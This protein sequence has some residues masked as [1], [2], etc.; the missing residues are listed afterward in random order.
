[1]TIAQRILT[2]WIAAALA[3]G[4][5]A[6]TYYVAPGGDNGNDGSAGAPWATIQYAVDNVVSGDVVHVEPGT[7]VESV[8]ITTDYITVQGDSAANTIV[9]SVNTS[10]HACE[11]TDAH[12][13][14]LRRFTF[15]G[16]SSGLYARNTTGQ[17]QGSVEDCI[18]SGNQYG[19]HGSGRNT[20]GQLPVVRCRIQ[21]NTS[22]GVYPQGTYWAPSLRNCLIVSNGSYGVYVALHNEAQY[23]VDVWNCTVA[24]N[25]GSG[26]H[27][28]Y[29]GDSVDVR[30]SI[31]ADNS[32]FGIDYSSDTFEGL[33]RPVADSLLHGNRD[34]AVSARAARAIDLKG[35]LL[36]ADPAFAGAGDYRLQSGSP[37]VDAGADLSGSGI[38][39][40]L[41]GNARSGAYDLGCYESAHTGPT[42]LAT[43]YVDATK[44]DNSGDGASW[45]TAKKDIG[46]ALAITA[47]GGACRVTNGVYDA[48]IFLSRKSQSVI[49]AGADSVT[50]TGAWQ[51]VRAFF[52][53]TNCTLEGVT[54]AGAAI[55]AL[56]DNMVAHLGTL[57]GCTI[58]NGG[59][60][61]RTGS[62]GGNANCRFT[63][64]S[65]RILNNSSNAV[66]QGQGAN[67]NRAADTITLRNC[68]LAGN[69]GYGVLINTYSEGSSGLSEL[70]NC[71][72][73]GNA[74]DGYRVPST[75]RRCA[76]IRNTIITANGGYGVSVPATMDRPTT[77]YD[78]LLYGNAGGSYGGNL[79]QIITSGNMLY[80]DPKLTPPR[81]TLQG[82]SPAIDAGSDL[83]AL[84]VTE[85]IDGVARPV[86][87]AY[88]MG[89]YESSVVIT[90]Y[91]DTYADAVNGS[92]ANA[93]TNWVTAK[94][95]ITAAL[96]ILN[97]GGRVHVGAG[98][99]NER[100]A[101]AVNNA[102]LLG[103]GYQ[104]TI[105]TGDFSNP[106]LGISA[107][108]VVVSNMQF[109]CGSVG[110]EFSG[111]GTYKG[112]VLDCLIVTN[113]IGVY[114]STATDYRDMELTRC[115][116]L[117]NRAEGVSMGM[118][119]GRTLDMVTLDNC[120][121]ARN[122]T[123]GIA[124]GTFAEQPAQR[125]NSLVRH[126]TIVRNAGQGCYI[127]AA[128][129]RNPVFYNT[130]LAFNAGYGVDTPA[131]ND[132]PVTLYDS[133][134]YGNGSGPF[135][136][137]GLQVYTYGRTRFADP[138]LG[139]DDCALQQGSAAIDAG[140]GLAAAGVSGDIDGASRPAGG[141]FDIGCHESAFTRAT[142]ME[143][144]VDA[145]RPNDLGT[146]TNWATARQTIGAALAF[147]A[148]SGTCYVARGVYAEP[149]HIGETNLTLAGLDGARDATVVEGQAGWAGITLDASGLAV[150]NLRSVGAAAGTRVAG[151]GSVGSIVNCCM[152]SNKVG[153]VAEGYPNR[154]LFVDRCRFTDNDIY[155]VNFG[156]WQRCMLTMRSSLIAG[157]G[158][159][160]VRLEAHTELPA[161]SVLEN[162]TFAHNGS[163]GLYAAA[164]LVEVRN[165]VVVGNAGDGL[166]H[167]GSGG[168]VAFTLL[169]GNSNN[170]PLGFT[171]G[172]SVITN[173]DPILRPDFIPPLESPVTDAGTNLSWTAEPDALDLA[174]TDR[175]LGKGVNMG[176]FEEYMPRGSIVIVK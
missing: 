132:K 80:I 60:G 21:N 34:G 95:T 24:T 69:G 6:S 42:L 22:H 129:K 97:E 171:L 40:D 119:A 45:A 114:S 172:S 116:I 46:E 141:G 4:A 55:G 176:A 5:L 128:Y 137:N 152:Q 168:P 140:R 130:I 23:A 143:T 19:I 147:T 43:T 65:C 170:V 139:A 37:A 101:L 133:L 111:S 107:T 13:L 86:G 67:R 108:N 50:V 51:Q 159:I 68:L 102:S 44:P 7:Y 88:D 11:I 167:A 10:S 82:D 77:L 14:L 57:R 31:V 25:N 9:Q 164:E 48:Q 62:S 162:C 98:V 92:D 53:A 142:Y 16:G 73:A 15:T 35:A 49:G 120:L 93:G 104:S 96:G 91:D 26:I 79:S 71:T 117:R 118:G 83:S 148:A 144:F 160:G 36:T 124:S 100:V 30:N 145:S 12:H 155:G 153:M 161:A 66:F 99:Y 8:V 156:S 157:N 136:G 134:V 39:D 76:N 74:L 112:R 33:N 54:L 123:H 59:V 127:P 174:G 32:G 58:E 29:N 158:D 41:D 115:R 151:G 38:T 81:Y 27:I 166:R 56:V 126:C 173:Q 87:S 3:S 2:A 135:G 149:V 110:I 150:R 109:T 121:I 28:L 146:G 131:N 85:D 138:L 165:A 18:F 122:G 70:Q 52:G 106:C 17:S 75:Y 169:Y 163:N 72:I 125:G 78:C 61:I 84:G 63:A 1:M 47:A 89:C 64:A 90:Y 113:G 154:S 20:Q 175:V 103:S 94:Q 105:V